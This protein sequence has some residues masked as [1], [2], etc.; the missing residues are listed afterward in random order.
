MLGLFNKSTINA[1]VIP[2]SILPPA[3]CWIG[4]YHCCPNAATAK[5]TMPPSKVAQPDP[6]VFRLTSFVS[7]SMATSFAAL[8]SGYSDGATQSLSL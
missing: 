5:P 1:V 6:F 4:K 8:K 3:S 2:K 7:K